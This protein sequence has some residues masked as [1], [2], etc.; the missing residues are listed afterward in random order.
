MKIDHKEFLPGTSGVVSIDIADLPSGT[1]IHLPIH[2]FRSETEGPTVLISGGLHGDE[3]N[4]VEIVRKTLV[5]QYFENLEI[6]SV[7][8]I[9][10]INIYGFI[11]FSRAVPDGKDVNRSFPGTSKGSLAS[12]VAHVLSTEII[13]LIDLGVDFH[14]GGASRYNYPQIRFSPASEKAK[15]Y[16][17]AFNAPVSI[18]SSII[19]KSFRE[20]AHKMGKDIIVFEGGESLRYDPLSIK[21]GL[22]GIKKLLTHLEMIHP[23]EIEKQNSK[24]FT[25]KS[26]QRAEISGLFIWSKSSGDEVKEGEVIAS[27]HD[28]HNTY[29]YEVKAKQDGFIIGH[30]NAPVVNQGDALFHFAT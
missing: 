25:S 30:N 8:V 5:N 10:L 3:V 7:I 15:E 16:A 9:P 18:E 17:M 24:Y 6:G 4:G 11:N 22:R 23:S 13:P 19:E 29:N 1:K 20:T 21:E 14:T 28:P 26:W 27:I 2:V 12:Q